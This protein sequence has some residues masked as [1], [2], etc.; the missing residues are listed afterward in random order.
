LA[1]GSRISVAQDK[2]LSVASSRAGSRSGNH[3]ADPAPQL[4]HLNSE[5]PC[6]ITLPGNN[7][8]A[9]CS[10]HVSIHAGHSPT[11]IR[12]FFDISVNSAAL[13]DLRRIG[14]GI[15]LNWPYT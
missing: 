10:E 11:A 7:V 2:H 6:N 13:T 14:G 15:G 8:K 1:F 9:C 12:L 5:E 4:G 3:S